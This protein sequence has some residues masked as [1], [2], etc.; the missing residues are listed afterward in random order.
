MIQS[1]A[2]DRLVIDKSPWYTFEP[3][4]LSRCETYFEEPRYIF[5]HRHPLSTI[6]SFLRARIGLV[7]RKSKT[8]QPEGL[9]DYE[10][11]ASTWLQC[12]DNVVRFLRSLPSERYL[13]VSFETLVSH[14]ETELRSICSFLQLQYDPDVLQPYRPGR[15]AD[16]IEGHSVPVGDPTFHLRDSIDEGCA[17][18]HEKLPMI[19]PFDKELVSLAQQLGYMP[20]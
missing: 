4:T 15:M 6:H 20:C 14:P 8:L 17:D 11:G 18:L 1:L 12:N 10:L 19:R 2:G 5:L 13:R 16:R 3:E 9:S 7:A